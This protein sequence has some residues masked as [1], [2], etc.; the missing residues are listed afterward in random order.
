MTFNYVG[1]DV[2]HGE[3][4]FKSIEYLAVWKTLE[5]HQ[6]ADKSA[7]R[8]AGTLGAS[9]AS[10]QGWLASQEVPD[11]DPVWD[12]VARHDRLSEMETDI[13]EALPELGRRLKD[14]PALQQDYDLMSVFVLILRDELDKLKRRIRSRAPR[15]ARP[16]AKATSQDKTDKKSIWRRF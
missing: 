3:A 13:S 2:G 16:E 1:K 14:N 15:E 9:D 7:R 11:D 10:I 5:E 4:Y 8:T 6:Q 12:W